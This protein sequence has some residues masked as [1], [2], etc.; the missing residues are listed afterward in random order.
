MELTKKDVVDMYRDQYENAVFRLEAAKN[1]LEALRIEQLTDES[2]ELDDEIEKIWSD[3]HDLIEQKMNA[4]SFLIGQ[5]GYS[6]LDLE[7]M[8]SEV[9][10]SFNESATEI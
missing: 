7:E 8:E 3:V 4:Y 1:T 9:L 6:P 2:K 5:S 10:E